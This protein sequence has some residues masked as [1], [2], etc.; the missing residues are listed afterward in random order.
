M[1]TPITDDSVNFH[2]LGLDKD[3]K[4]IKDCKEFKLN[5][6]TYNFTYDKKVHYSKSEFATLKVGDETV[7]NAKLKKEGSNIVLA[8]KL[9]RDTMPFS[10]TY[11]SD[12]LDI[13]S[14][15]GGTCKLFIYIIFQRLKLNVDFIVLNPKVLSEELELS[16]TT[17]YTSIVHLIKLGFI[18]RQQDEDTLYWINPHKIFRGDRK[19]IRFIKL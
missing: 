3:I 13:K 15:S 18:A 4:S 11:L 1:I 9:Y 5:P 12:A 17:I 6:F 7:D 14:L 2:S 16:T 8:E 19:K 10:K